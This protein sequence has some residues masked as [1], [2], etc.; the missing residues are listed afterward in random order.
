MPGDISIA[1]PAGK[2]GSLR[3]SI[4]NTAGKNGSLRNRRSVKD[5]SMPSK[6]SSASP[7]HDKPH[8]ISFRVHPEMF[9]KGVNFVFIF[10]F[11]SLIT[12]LTFGYR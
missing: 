10:W 5:L 12:F 8:R 6:R 9:R 2:N 11:L 4:A 1:N 3:I 7:S